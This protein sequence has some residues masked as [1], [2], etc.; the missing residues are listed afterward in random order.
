MASCPSCNLDSSNLDIR[1][2]HYDYHPQYHYIHYQHWNPKPISLFCSPQKPVFVFDEN[3]VFSVVHH[4]RLHENLLQEGWR[5]QHQLFFVKSYQSYVG[6]FYLKITTT[7]FLCQKL[8]IIGIFYL[9]IETTTFFCQKFP[10]IETRYILFAEPCE[11]RMNIKNFS[12]SKVTNH[13]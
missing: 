5:L 9:K 1:H 3:I 11:W 8:P 7:T 4:H 2:Q 6:I 13:I 10:I 12:S